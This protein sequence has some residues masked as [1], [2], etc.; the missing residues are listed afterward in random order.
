MEEL[1]NQILNLIKDR[2]ESI[3][4]S[5]K[6][7]KPPSLTLTNKEIEMCQRELIEDSVINELTNQL[8]NI[9]KY[10]I[11]KLIITEPLFF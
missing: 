2:Q 9:E 10:S 5:Y 3:I 4:N 8:V 11:H 6:F 7:N 1:K